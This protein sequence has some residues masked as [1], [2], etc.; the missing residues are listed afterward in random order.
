MLHLANSKSQVAVMLLFVTAISEEISAD[1]IQPTNW[2]SCYVDIKDIF[3]TLHYLSAASNS[4]ETLP[5]FIESKLTNT[6]RNMVHLETVKNRLQQNIEQCLTSITDHYYNLYNMDYDSLERMYLESL[7]KEKRKFFL[8]VYNFTRCVTNSTES[9]DFTEINWTTVKSYAD[10]LTLEI[11]H[12][13]NDEH[14]Q[15]LLRSYIQPVLQGIIFVTGLVSNGI[16]LAIF[17][18]HKEM[19]TSTNI[20]LINLVVGDIYS[21]VVNLPLFYIYST[22]TT[23][24]LGEETC[25]LLRFS[26][27]LGIGVN[28]FSV[29]A[30]SVQRY[31][32]ALKSSRG[33]KLKRQ[34]STFL[35]VCVWVLACL[36]AAPHTFFAGFY[37]SRCSNSGIKHES[38]ITI[39]TL[40]E[41]IMLCI[42][43]VVTIS[44]FTILTGC[45]LSFTVD[46]K[47]KKE[48][49][50][51]RRVTNI[52][53]VLTIVVTISYV[54]YYV[55]RFLYIWCGLELSLKSHTVLQVVLYTLMFC[56]ACFNP[57]AM[58][59]VSQTF[60]RYFHFYLFWCCGE[61]EDNNNTDLTSYA[62]DVIQS[63]TQY[64]T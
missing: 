40:F 28:I 63:T 4:E 7:I 51:V 26:R 1:I 44:F 27:H 11:V 62:E 14:E 54:P 17:V 15:M 20:M 52:L 31:C 49:Q 16:L 53:A 29:T 59:I 42:F 6:S 2:K 18:K 24:K 34:L 39:I 46:K 55:Y 19:R 48:R 45:T 25:K 21:L 8:E 5:Q 56:N 22:F 41:F 9:D 10:N 50:A 30:L 37:G 60:R 36:F 43:P 3:S 57:V 32:A 33:K 64:N 13:E 58:Y 12:I 35:V 61:V 47:A 23:W 38:Y